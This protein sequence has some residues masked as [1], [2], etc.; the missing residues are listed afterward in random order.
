MT[1]MRG[2]VLDDIL[3]DEGMNPYSIE[4]EL[5]DAGGWLL[6]TCIDLFAC[7]LLLATDLVAVW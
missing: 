4:H 5:N 2:R 3:G 7:R 6:A 1:E